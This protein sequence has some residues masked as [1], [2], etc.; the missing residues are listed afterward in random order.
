MNEWVGIGNLAKE[1]EYK[2]GQKGPVCKFTVAIN[3][4][5]GD[6]EEVNYIPVVTFG[7]TADNC[8]RFLHKGHKVAVHGRIK[9][10][11]YE[12]KQGQKVYTTDVVSAHVEFLTPKNQGGQPTYQQ[13]PQQNQGFGQQQSFDP[14]GF[15][16]TEEDMPS[17]M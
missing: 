11:S 16:M 10:G 5:W 7:K 3:D 1:P 2:Q 4:G 17:F 8:A 13:K 6:K 12:N 15:G 9:T 14:A